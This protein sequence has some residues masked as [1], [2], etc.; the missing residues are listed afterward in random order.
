MDRLSS[1]FAAADAYRAAGDGGL[2]LVSVAHV[3][4]LMD[5]ELTLLVSPFVFAYQLPVCEIDTVKRAL[6]FLGPKPEKLF[7]FWKLRSDVFVLPNIL[8]QD[9][10]VIWQAIENACQ[11]E[12][13]LLIQGVDFGQRL[14]VVR[15]K[16]RQL[17]NRPPV[18]DERLADIS[19]ELTLL[20]E[21]LVGCIH[22]NCDL[23]SSITRYRNST[24]CAGQ[25]NEGDR[26]CSL[27]RIGYRSRTK[28][29]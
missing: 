9:E 12:T 14:Y 19:I 25:T 24:C 8:L 13:V 2:G 20:Y 26:S 15:K 1:L 6:E 17:H 28:N 7:E 21:K 27:N 4:S 16:S 5:S 11:Y 3:G 23:K 18:L 10:L 29:P 22:L